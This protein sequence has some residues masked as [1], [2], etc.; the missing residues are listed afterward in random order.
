MDMCAVDVCV[1]VCVCVY[2]Y[3]YVSMCVC[4]CMHMYLCVYVS[5]CLCVCVSACGAGGEF[6]LEVRSQVERLPQS[7]TE[8]GTHRFSLSRLASWQQALGILLSLPT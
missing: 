5:V 3:V 1:S 2:V 6:H 8:S 7:L 4:V